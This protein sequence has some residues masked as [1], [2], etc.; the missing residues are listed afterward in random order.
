MSVD[1]STFSNPS[2]FHGKSKLIRFIWMFVS[3]LFFNTWVPF[4]S[5]FKAF[6]LR[7][8]G[9]TVGKGLVIRTFVRIKQPWR[10][11]IGD[12]VWIG[13]SVWIDNLVHV[14]IGSNV[15]LS[16]GVFLLTG[17][18]NYKSTS[19]DLITGEIYLEAG[20]WIG[21]NAI[22]CPGVTCQMHS[23][24]SVGSVA[25]KNLEASSIYQGNPA[26]FKKN[27]IFIN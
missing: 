7:L 18:H 10:L 11:S 19:F 25:T 5:T 2:F 1:L 3:R 13:E 20:V 26:I 27:R 9:A 23:M 12:N 21:A 17:N 6:I 4:P 15:C 16:Q 24:L 8:F 22:V 14:S